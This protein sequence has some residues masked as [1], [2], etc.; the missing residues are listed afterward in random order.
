MMRDD[1]ELLRSVKEMAELLEFP[2][3]K[4]HVAKAQAL[5]LSIARRAPTGRAANLA[6]QL[7]S[8]V[9]ALQE[10]ELPLR[11][12]S[13]RLNRILESLRRTLEEARTER[14]K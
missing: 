14:Q 1:D 6:M 2:R 8:E 12:S 4:G 5:A 7:I 3:V 13:A 11:P 10:T 9:N